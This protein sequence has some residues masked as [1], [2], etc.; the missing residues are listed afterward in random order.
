MSPMELNRR[1]KILSGVFI[2]TEDSGN[3]E[4]AQFAVAQVLPGYQEIHLPFFLKE[5]QSI[6][7]STQD[8]S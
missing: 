8:Y 1:T 3:F 7:E 4:E 5:R 6:H 2:R